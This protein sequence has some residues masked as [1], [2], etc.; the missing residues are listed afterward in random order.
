MG[1]CLVV[2]EAEKEAQIFGRQAALG[3]VLVAARD[4][5]EEGLAEG[6][7]GVVLLIVIYNARDEVESE[8]GVDTVAAALAKASNPAQAA[9]E[10]VVF[11]CHVRRAGKDVMWCV[12]N[13][14]GVF[15]SL[16]DTFLVDYSTKMQS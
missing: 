4:A 8:G 7:V 3:V 14:E 9:G 2:S 11:V 10:D 15:L 5:R 1:G 12:C 13:R 6:L 16:L